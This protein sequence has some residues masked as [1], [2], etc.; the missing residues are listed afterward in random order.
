MRLVL[1][2]WQSF[3][4]AR[5]SQPS[6]DSSLLDLLKE[7][8]PR[9]ASD[10]QAALDAAVDI[11]DVSLS[12]SRPRFLAYVGSSGLEIGVLADTLMATHDINL[13]TGSGATDRLE[14][15]TIEWVGEFVGFD[16]KAA[17][18]FAGGGTI[19][20]LTALTAARESAA[21]GIRREGV[22]G[23]RLAMYCSSE[24]HYSVQRAA[25]LL[26]IGA[27]N[28]RRI[29]LDREHRMDVTACA[30]AIDSDRR[31][32]V[33]PVAVVA[34]AGTTLTGAVDD[35]DGLADVCEARDMWLHVD[36]AYGAPAAATTSAG[37]RFSGIER[38]DSVTIDAHKWLYVPKPCSL[39]LVHDVDPLVAAF[40]HHEG[41]IPHGAE[42]HA[43]DRTLEYSRPVS[44]LKVWLA[45]RVHGA[46]AIRSAIDTN[47]GQAKLLA[48]LIQA[49]ERFELLMEPQL[50]VVCFRRVGVADEDQHNRALS[51]ALTREGRILIAPAEANGRTWLRACFVNHRTSDEDVHLTMRAVN[52]ASAALS[53]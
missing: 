5:A 50:S 30:E 6:P 2:A 20:N 39:L 1:D 28:V 27:D 14:A 7:G 11:L 41:Y 10:P 26:G 23:R 34:T 42:L 12:Q 22:G 24:A 49:D 37:A 44:A 38:A 43:V 33:I 31:Q 46:D 18:L 9:K 29:P 17:G 8:L 47:L 35:L 40:S 51:A 21:P 15:Q 53:D 32:G 13:A 45:F 16:R 52:E 4:Q 48:S 3:D 36:G 19:S 25:E